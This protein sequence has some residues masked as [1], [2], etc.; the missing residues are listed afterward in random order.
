MGTYL[1]SLV[2]NPTAPG[3]SGCEQERLVG[4][5]GCVSRSQAAAS[6]K[7][8]APAICHLRAAGS[9]EAATTKTTKVATTLVENCPPRRQSLF[10]TR[11]LKLKPRDLQ[12]CANSSRPHPPPCPA[13]YS[14]PCHDSLSSQCRW[15][16]AACLPPVCG[17]L[18]IHPPC[19]LCLPH[20]LACRDRLSVTPAGQRGQPLRVR[21]RRDPQVCLHEASRP[22]LVDRPAQGITP[23]RS[24]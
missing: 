22:S 17:T 9:G 3:R 18:D 21:Q 6:F 11:P 20:H 12:T 7:F 8:W 23:A 16:S 4:Q 24:Q 5:E 10:P 14:V 19:S 2:S 13:A 15:S 1:G